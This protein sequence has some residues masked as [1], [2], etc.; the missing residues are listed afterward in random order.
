MSEI[1]TLGER[2]RRFAASPDDQDWPDV[3]RRGGAAPPRHTGSTPGSRRNIRFVLALG[4]IVVS[5]AVVAVA[6]LE[7]GRDTRPLSNGHR[8]HGLT[9]A[10]IHLAGYQFRTPA[11]FKTSSRA[12]DAMPSGPGLWTVIHGVAAAASAEG[13]CVDGGIAALASSAGPKPIRAGIPRSAEPVA[14]GDY[15][16][17]FLAHAP[18]DG[19]AVSPTSP[20]PCPPPQAKSL[21]YVYLPDASGA[22]HSVYVVLLAQGLT[23]DQLIA[24]AESGLQ[25]LPPPSTTTT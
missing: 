20:P 13:G 10:T 23:K 18:P 12:C 15:Q 21:L 8:L 3:L 1:E 4:G 5:A 22:G 16:G 24:V 14:V 2:L 7:T 17:Y 19:C 25:K 11:G 9:G 6:A